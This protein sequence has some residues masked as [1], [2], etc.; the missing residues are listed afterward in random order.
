[1]RRK[2]G[3]RCA[4][5]GPGLCAWPG[6]L[7]IAA[8]VFTEDPRNGLIRLAISAVGLFR[9]LDTIR[10]EAEELERRFAERRGLGH[11][12]DGIFSASGMR[13]VLRVMVPRWSI[14]RQSC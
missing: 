8:E 11:E 10:A 1:M 5:P 4:T 9:L 12:R 7:P 14:G 13:T 6:T 2:S 3:R